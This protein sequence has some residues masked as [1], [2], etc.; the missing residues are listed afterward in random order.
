MAARFARDGV[1]VLLPDGRMQKAGPSVAEIEAGAKPEWLAAGPDGS[2]SKAGAYHTARGIVRMRRDGYRMRDEAR[3]EMETA[4]DARDSSTG[5]LRDALSKEVARRRKAFDEVLKETEPMISR[6]SEEMY[7]DYEAA[8]KRWDAEPEFGDWA[9]GFS[10]RLTESFNAMLDFMASIGEKSKADVQ[11]WKKMFPDYTPTERV[12]GADEGW[13]VKIPGKKGERAPNLSRQASGSGEAIVD[14]RLVHQQRLLKFAEVFNRNRVGHALD[15]LKNQPGAGPF[16]QAYEREA[17]ARTE[18]GLEKSEELRKAGLSG[19][20]IGRALKDMEIADSEVYFRHEPWPED[21]RKATYEYMVDGKLTSVRV[22]DRALYDLITNQQVDAHQTARIVR[23]IAQMEVLGVKPVQAQAQVVRTLAT[24]ASAAFQFKN[25]P[26]DTLSFW[27]NTTDRA[28]VFQ[29]VPEYWKMAGRFARE[30]GHNLG[31]KVL[32]RDADRPRT[33]EDPL[34]EAFRDARGD[35]LKQFAFERDNPEK[36]YDGLKT[37]PNIGSLVK[38]AL[39]WLG[40]PEL[41]PRFLEWKNNVERMTGR[42]QEQLRAEYAA[43]QKDIK[44]G[45]KATD[46]LTE[47]Q[48]ALL[49]NA[50]WEVTSPFP[51]QGT[52]TREFN[53]ITPFFGPAVAGVSKAIRNWKTNPK[54]ALYALGAVAALRA[55]HWALVKDEPWYDQL[56]AND[57]FNNFVVPT[58]FGPR[59]LPGPRDLDVAFGGTLVTA[60]DMANGKDARFKQLLE[61]STEAVLPPGIGPA[62]GDAIKGDVGMAAARVG[63]MP[64]G[65]VGTVAVEMMMNRDWTGKPIVPRREEGKTSGFDQFT[66]HYGPYALKQ[67]TGGRGELSLSGAGLNLVP[68]VQNLRESVDR[69][70]DR[71]HELEVE[72]VKA[73]RAGRRFAA[74][75]EW[76][77]LQ[78][79]KAQVEKLAQ[80]GRGERKVGTRVV[81][82]YRPGADERQDIML[83]QAEIAGRALR[84]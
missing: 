70:Y 23:S 39:N 83:K 1:H 52:V 64:A 81:T 38:D 5:A 22:G 40:S 6:V 14:P 45:R 29:L 8:L 31:T 73:T 76:D 41:A 25:V 12:L 13:N 79:A 18:K 69:M 50:A 15:L 46:P 37:T 47:G 9:K 65:P 48:K 19:D 26:R 33:A 44:A 82:G 51:R 74:E 66:D 36:M 61:Q 75:A 72:R 34:W 10:A 11:R 77:R 28:T 42:T 80:Q 67:L 71:I 27:R 56:S 43:Y 55:L 2:A 84:K 63:A 59:R 4:I 57:K 68:R 58:P 3:G 20:Q 60:L 30:F 16:V 21:G 32:K 49:L 7:A 62:A 78:A 54:G 24:G 17:G 53:K 35:Q